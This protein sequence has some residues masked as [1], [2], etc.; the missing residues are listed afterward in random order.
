MA[1]LLSPTGSE[2]IKMSSLDATRARAQ[3]RPATGK[4][5]WKKSNNGN[6]YLSFYDLKISVFPNT[7]RGGWTVS[8]A[9][10]GETPTYSGH[11]TE[12]EARAFGEQKFSNL[13][14]SGDFKAPSPRSLREVVEE[15]LED[16]RIPPTLEGDYVEL[17]ARLERKADRA[18]LFRLD[19]SDDGLGNLYWVPHSQGALIEDHTGLCRLIVTRWW[20]DR[21][22]PAQ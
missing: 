10:N 2:F 22:R 13:K 3:G 1:A 17:S 15:M 11:A 7:R 18:D 12:T 14:S 5:R 20:L 4:P 8:V 19:L 16:G 9:E 6:H 21:A